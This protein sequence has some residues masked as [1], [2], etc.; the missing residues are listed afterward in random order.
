MADETIWQAVLQPVPLMSDQTSFRQKDVQMIVL[1]RKL[2]SVGVPDEE[3]YGLFGTLQDGIGSAEKVGKL[4][5][6]RFGLL[7]QIHERQRVLDDLDYYTET[8]RKTR[9]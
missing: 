3:L 7:A 6:T 1:L 8:L 9:R 5:R 2:R 4:R